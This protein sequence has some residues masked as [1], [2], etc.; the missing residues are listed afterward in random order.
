MSLII[1]PECGHDLSTKAARC[2]NC[3]APVPSVSAATTDGAALAPGAR[4]ATPEAPGIPRRAPPPAKMSV[5]N[6]FWNAPEQRLRAAWRLVLT[7]C[8][9]VLLAVLVASVGLRLLIG[10][11][12]LRL[13]GGGAAP[14]GDAGHSLLYLLQDGLVALLTGLLTV[15]LCGRPLDR[16]PFAGFGLALSRQW[17]Q[18]LGLGLGAALVVVIF[19]I[20]DGA[21]WI[22]VA[23]GAPPALAA[24]GTG[25]ALVAGLIGCTSNGI[26]VELLFRG[27]LLRNLAEGLR[28]PLRGSQAAI[29]VAW[30]L[31]STVGGYFVHSG[32]H[33]P[34]LSMPVMTAV[35]LLLGLGYILTGQLALPIG[36]SIAGTFFE[37]CVFGFPFGGQAG[38]SALL[39]TRQGGP[40]LWTG[41]AFGP[42][43]GLITVVVVLVFA[44]LVAWIA[45]ARYG[46]LALQVDLA[47]PP[48][49]SV[50]AAG[51]SAEPAA[52]EA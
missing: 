8:A 21:G 11:V 38:F 26:A 37:G 30:L 25:A 39:T 15:W 28:G 48:A 14:A 24:Y 19:L 17:W 1:C 51:K 6:P 45:R 47:D 42:Q 23:F 18:D 40:D 36:L 34:G 50:A 22:R 43:G 44:A 2:P 27:Y 52:E 20:E 3:G 13:L 49:G 12:I 46:K 7:S 16:R 32:Q 41:G 33:A 4:A 31:S 10:P 29:V 5:A 9:F 35:N